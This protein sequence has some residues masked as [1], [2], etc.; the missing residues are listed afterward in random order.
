MS[1]LRRPR[2]DSA[3]AQLSRSGAPPHPPPQAGKPMETSLRLRGGGGLRIH[4]KE[5]LPL[6]YNS[7]LQVGGVP[8]LSSSADI[9]FHLIHLFLPIHGR[10]MARSTQL[11]PPGLLPRATLLSSSGTSPP[12]SAPSRSMTANQSIL[13]LLMLPNGMSSPLDIGR[14]RSWRPASQRRRH[15][16]QPSRQDGPS[17]HPRW[18]ARAKP[19]RPPAY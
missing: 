11:P 17:I 18:I 13:H 7:L 8:F 9:P 14:R 16:L 15:H 10:L 4:A 12:R 19:Q 6:G 2:P 3:P 1:P 5:K